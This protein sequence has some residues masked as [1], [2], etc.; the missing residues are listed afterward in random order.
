M[1]FLTKLPQEEQPFLKAFNIPY[2]LRKE[3]QEEVVGMKWRKNKVR[4]QEH[5]AEGPHCRLL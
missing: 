1:L 3:A 2:N 5:M 4:S